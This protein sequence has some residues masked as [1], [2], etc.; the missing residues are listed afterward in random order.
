M[1]DGSPLPG[2]VTIQS[3]CGSQHR[4]V[5]HSGPNGDFGFQWGNTNGVFEDA[6]ENLRLPGNLTSGSG[7]SSS[8]TGSSASGSV[9]DPL[10]N[11]D[12]RAELG[13]YTSTRVSLFNH[14]SFD[15]FDIGSIV[16]HRVNGDEGRTV[17][18][19][20]LKAPKD[21]KKNFDKGAE[22]V[23]TKKLADAAVS[24]QKA[25]ASY[26]QYADAWL[27]LGRVQSLMGAKEDA[28][29]SFQKSMD[30]D[31]KLVGPWQEL[32][33][34]AS[35]ASRWEDA[36]RYLDQAVRLDPVDSAMAWYFG[37]M[38]NYN[39]GRFDVAEREIRAEMKMY[40][41]RNPRADYLLGVILISRKDLAGGA[42]ALRRYIAAAP[43]APETET[44]RKQ[45]SRIES[46]IAQ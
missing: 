34:L 31:N 2:S 35:D 14:S 33:Y 25:V 38:A 9:Y 18:M 27:S 17:S 3:V 40:Q 13:G 36:A 23:K 6:S 29:I 21:A 11:C 30:L 39:L 42:E 37:A 24:F 20:S 8:A 5:A 15:G 10:S 16:L 7:G 43:T 12:L 1:D 4:N 41:G 22:Q 44:A 32:G 26:P 45:L 28:R 19:L 46:Q